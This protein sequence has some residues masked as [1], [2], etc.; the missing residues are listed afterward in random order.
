[1]QSPTL[2]QR[3]AALFNSTAVHASF[4]DIELAQ[5]TLRE[6][7]NRGLDFEGCLKSTDDPQL[8]RFQG[9]PQ[10]VIQLRKFAEAVRRIKGAVGTADKPAAAPSGRAGAAAGGVAEGGGYLGRDMSSMLRTEM[11]GIDPSLG[12]IFRRVAGLLVTGLVLGSVLF[13]VGLKLAF[14]NYN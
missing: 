11:T 7:V 8:V 6:G 13:Y 14:P 2:S 10:I 1:M 4:G 9:S 3:H 12:G 5:I